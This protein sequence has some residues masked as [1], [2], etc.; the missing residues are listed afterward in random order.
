M[1]RGEKCVTC[2]WTSL[3]LVAAEE[4]KGISAKHQRS[5]DK[6]R[7][8]HIYC[9]EEQLWRQKGTSIRQLYYS[10]SVSV[11]VSACAPVFDVVQLVG[12]SLKTC[13][14][15]SVLVLLT[16]ST[17]VVVSTTVVNG[18]TNGNPIEVQFEVQSSLVNDKHMYT[19]QTVCR[20]EDID[21]LFIWL[22]L[23]LNLVCVQNIV[24]RTVLHLFNVK[25]MVFL[26]SCATR[27]SKDIWNSCEFSHF[28]NCV[29]CEWMSVVIAWC[30]QSYGC[31]K[32]YG[33]RRVQ[34]TYEKIIASTI[35]LPFWTY[36][37]QKQRTKQTKRA[38]KIHR[39]HCRLDKVAKNRPLIL[40]LARAVQKL[41]KFDR[42]ACSRRV[43]G[44][45]SA[46]WKQ[47]NSNSWVVRVW[48]TSG[49]RVRRRRSRSY[50]QW[51]S[52]K[53]HSMHSVYALCQSD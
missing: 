29:D 1:P 32:P 20:E 14:I 23:E 15:H 25:S 31:D 49:P 5:T 33:K 48:C 46:V 40:R 42:H 8:V 4:Q 10:V 7:R 43:T 27:Q 18:R 3:N 21:S 2:I 19:Q 44:S 30:T 37:D 13:C 22:E 24:G 11:C 9:R 45:T 47:T 12:C 17:I 36:D 51:F 39:S 38:K 41:M 50:S 6:N 34:M 53:T 52:I 35:V 26:F 28:R 16:G